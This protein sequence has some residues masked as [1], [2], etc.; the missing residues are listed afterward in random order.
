[1]CWTID[2]YFYSLHIGW[3]P[4]RILKY[5]SEADEILVEYNSEPGLTY[6]MNVKKSVADEQL[7]LARSTTTNLDTYDQLIEVGTRIHLKFTKTEKY[8]TK[9]R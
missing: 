5:N 1:M 7:K 4:A 2:L 3:F 8:Q 9:A 6:T